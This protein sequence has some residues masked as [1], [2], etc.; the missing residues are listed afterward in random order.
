MVARVDAT[1]PPRY[2][3]LGKLGR[4]FQLAGGLRF[5][6]AGAWE[7]DAVIAVERVF[8]EG[9]GESP[10]REVRAH[11]GEQI[12]YLTRARNRDQAR[13][14]ANAEVYVDPALLPEDDEDTLYLDDLI[15]TPVVSLGVAPGP[16]AGT[17]DVV[18]EVVEVIEGP[19]QDLLVVETATGRV[20][21]P[22]QA[23]YVRFDG[24]RVQLV[25]PPE[26]L[27]DG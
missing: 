24:E 13:A 27:L 5:H 21:L 9:L 1:P 16:S 15:G 22:W 25:D 10:I 14:L 12:L 17:G 11:G 3:Y 2:R 23:P 26:G 20:L 4:A 8:V 19:S 18:G 6:A 7:A